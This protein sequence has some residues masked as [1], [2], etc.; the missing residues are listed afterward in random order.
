MESVSI[1]F[2]F[3]KY[4]IFIAAV[5]NLLLKHIFISWESP[6]YQLSWGFPSQTH[7]RILSQTIHQLRYIHVGLRFVEIWS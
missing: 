5:V 1:F 3:K 7:I 2:L 6:F 4:M